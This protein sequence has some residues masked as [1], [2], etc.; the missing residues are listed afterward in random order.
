MAAERSSQVVRHSRE[1]RIPEPFRFHLQVG[2][3]GLFD[4]ANADNG[5]SQLAGKGFQQALLIGHERGSLARADSQHAD[6]AAL[7]RQRNEQEPQRRQRVGSQPGP[8]A[9]VEHP[10]GNAVI[11]VGKGRGGQRIAFQVRRPTDRILLRNQEVQVAGKGAADVPRGRFQHRGQRS[12]AGQLAT[13]GVEGGGAAFAL[14]GSLDLIADASGQGAHNQAR[15]EHDQ[16]RE[17]VLGVADGEAEVRLDEQDVEDHDAQHRR[18]DRRS[19]P[20]AERHH[21]R[22]EQEHHADIGRLEIGKQQH[23]TADQAAD[24]HYRQRPQ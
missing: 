4:R 1:Q 14:A 20:K 16:E 9:V 21:D 17:D 15:R 12:R 13:H 19:A 5:Q 18:Q 11:V 7:C 3:L 2:P 23:P 24:G 10:P 6:R 22:A 8:L